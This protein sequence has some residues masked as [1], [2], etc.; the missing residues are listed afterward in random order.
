M[1]KI[2]SRIVRSHKGERYAFKA[3]NKKTRLEYWAKCEPATFSWIN[4]KPFRFCNLI[5]DAKKRARSKFAKSIQAI[6]EE[7]ATQVGSI[8]PQKELE[9]K[10]RVASYFAIRDLYD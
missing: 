6:K 3:I 7:I 8:L 9:F 2:P 5:W 10:A 4:N 1:T